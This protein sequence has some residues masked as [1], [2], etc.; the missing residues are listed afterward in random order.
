MG[1][2]SVDPRSAVV[3]MGGTLAWAGLG[4]GYGW[5]SFAFPQA[6]NFNAGDQNFQKKGLVSAREAQA[7]IITEAQDRLHFASF[8]VITDSR[9]ELVDMLRRRVTR[10]RRPSPGC[11]AAASMTRACGA[12]RTT[13]FFDASRICRRTLCATACSLRT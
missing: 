11:A 3:L 2:T 1:A 9:E 4:V 12:W 6:L 5:T 7:G 8:D 13:P 10:P